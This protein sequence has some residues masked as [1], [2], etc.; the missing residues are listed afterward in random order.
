MDLLRSHFNLWSYGFPIRRPQVR[1]LP[2]V[3]GKAAETTDDSKSQGASK[4]ASSQGV[5]LAP[6]DGPTPSKNPVN[7]PTDDSRSTIEVTR[8]D[9][10]DNKLSNKP[11][12]LAEVVEVWPK[13][14]DAIRS[15]IL[16]LV[17]ASIDK[18]ES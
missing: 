2:G 13:L 17:R 10:L 16:T 3:L 5:T 6:P 11:D 14:P 9:K 15:A 8:S 7:V 18:H 12:E 4:Y 1:I